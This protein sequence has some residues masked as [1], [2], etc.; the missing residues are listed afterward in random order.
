MN[1]EAKSLYLVA[2]DVKSRGWSSTVVLRAY[3]PVLLVAPG[4][5]VVPGGRKRSA[6]KRC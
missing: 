1:A 4:V 6:Q 2:S 3:R 5:D